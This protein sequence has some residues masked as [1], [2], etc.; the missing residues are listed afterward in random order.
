MM[1]RALTGMKFVR[2]DASDL[3]PF[4]TLWSPPG[5]ALS[6]SNV[7]TA[8]AVLFRTSPSVYAYVLRVWNAKT[9]PCVETT[10]P[11]RH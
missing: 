6:V 2:I 11:I 5:R 7:F 9:C 8:S 1:Y 4:V 10:S 3:V